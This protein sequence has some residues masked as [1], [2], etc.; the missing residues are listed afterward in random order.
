[1]TFKLD[2]NRLLMV[3]RDRHVLV[4]RLEM[5]LKESKMDG[6]G[7]AF[8][9]NALLNHQRSELKVLEQQL[10]DN[11]ASQEMMDSIK[12][13]E[14]KREDEAAVNRIRSQIDEWIRYEL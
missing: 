7:D 10:K 12:K 8:R 2:P 1:M 4:H 3:I 11:T 14:M 5:A 13:E 6:K 9:I